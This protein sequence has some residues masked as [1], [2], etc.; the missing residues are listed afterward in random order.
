[1]SFFKPFRDPESK[2]TYRDWIWPNVN[3]QAGAVW[4]TQQAFA[5]AAFCAVLTGVISLLGV[6][7]VPSVQELGFGYGTLLDAAIFA[8]I[9]FGIWKQSIF[10]AW[11]GLLFY[12]FERV[13]DWIL[14]DTKG[15]FISFAFLFAFV[16]GVRG[17]VALRRTKQS[18]SATQSATYP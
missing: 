17:T 4:A 15:L 11:S 6:I 10:A 1:M 18:N 8:M 13:G 3:T 5:A 2:R 7:G 12:C 14:F 9:A 16:A